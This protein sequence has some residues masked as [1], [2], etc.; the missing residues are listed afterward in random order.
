MGK[1][2]FFRKKKKKG[3]TNN[4]IVTLPSLALMSQFLKSSNKR[5]WPPPS[6]SPGFVP[7]PSWAQAES[8]AKNV[9]MMSVENNVDTSACVYVEKYVYLSRIL[10]WRLVCWV[11]LLPFWWV[12]VSDS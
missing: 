7:A 3:K 9:D 8:A 10:T 12:F 6:S 2:S 4:N 1:Y 5:L 11:L